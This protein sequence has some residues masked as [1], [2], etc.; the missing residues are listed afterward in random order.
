MAQDTRLA[1]L[2]HVLIHMHLHGGITTSATLA[3]MLHTNAVVVR[4]TMAS[5]RAAGLVASTSGRG[6]GWVLA[7]ELERV[8]ARD[9]YDAIAHATTFAIGPAQDNPS[10]PVEAAVNG[11][12]GEALQ[13]AESALL[14]RLGA[15]TLA[16]LA[17]EIVA[18]KT[19]A[20]PR[21]P[22]RAP[23][24]DSKRGEAKVKAKR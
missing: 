22:A 13:D 11:L 2:L 19:V 18:R 15:R 1:R 17:Q 8:T 5:L 7:R 9:V 4:R 16:D 10:C 12:L 23:E 6:G 14:Q 24:P 21:A 20:R 3:Q